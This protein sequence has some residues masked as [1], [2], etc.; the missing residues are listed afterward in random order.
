MMPAPVGSEDP[1][2]TGGR[3]RQYFLQPTP[4]VL[5]S[6]TGVW[7]I[8]KWPP[9]ALL[10]A[11]RNNLYVVAGAERE[12][13]PADVASEPSLTAAQGQDAGTLYGLFG[14]AGASASVIGALAGEIPRWDEDNTR[15]PLEWPPPAQI[16]WGGPQIG[17]CAV[18]ANGKLAY[19]DERIAAEND[20]KPPGDRAAAGTPEAGWFPDVLGD[21]LGADVIGVQFFQNYCLILDDQNRLFASVVLARNANPEYDPDQP[22]SEANDPLASTDREGTGQIPRYRFDLAQVLQRSLEPDPWVAM[23]S[24]AD[25]LLLFGSNTMG[26]WQ[27]KA[28]PGAGFPLERILGEQHEVGVFS[29]GSI[30]S[31]GDKAYWVG[32]TAQGQVR[33]FRYGGEDGVTAISTTAV[34]NYL[35]QVRGSSRVRAR[36]TATALSGRMC[37]AMRF[38]DRSE[39]RRKRLDATWCFDETTGMWHERG[40]WVPDRDGRGLGGWEQW[41]VVFA[42]QF[43][44]RPYVIAAAPAAYDASKSMVGYLTVQRGSDGDWVDA[45]FTGRRRPGERFER[46]TA[47]SSGVIR[48]ERVTPHWGTREEVLSIRGV[49]VSVG[50]GGGDVQLSMSKDGGRTY[51]LRGLTQTPSLGADEL[52]WFA[53]GQGRDPVVK[54]TMPGRS[55][56][57]NNVWANILRL[58]G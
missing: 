44:E 43:Q 21:A 11:G 12:I 7:D 14:R 10:A 23:L 2:S 45:A 41:E 42:V 34:D 1:A 53:L 47:D 4:G 29:Q 8:P 56:A 55:A 46:P 58:R 31:M 17:I 15:E 19:Y 22:I 16:A 5:R 40:V 26:A 9:R 35:G 48:R 51:S 33:A 25:R 32:A 38:D 30:A 36:C 52:R 39:G 24:L 6:S 57:L 27:L 37:F 54:I 13:T 49:K 18:A 28:N 20:A 3:R 50:Q